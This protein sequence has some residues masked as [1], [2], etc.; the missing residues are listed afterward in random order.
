MTSLW[1]HF[2]SHGFHVCLCCV[3]YNRLSAWKVSMLW[4]VWV[5]FY[6]GIW[7]NTMMTSSW[8]HFKFLGFEICIPHETD[9]RLYISPPSFKS[10]KSLLSGSN[11]SEVSIRHQ[12]H[13]YDAIMTS[14]HNTGFSKLHILLNITQAISLVRFIGLGCL[15]QILW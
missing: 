7:K 5:K 2:F 14:F 13:N 1:R 4:V 8:C 6:R 11:F 15:D 10:L 3:I 9:Y 12:R